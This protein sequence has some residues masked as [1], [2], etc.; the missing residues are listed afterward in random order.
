MLVAYS[1]DLVL[2]MPCPGTSI[3]IVVE[4]VKVLREDPRTSILFLYRTF[5]HVRAK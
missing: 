1:E 2:Y 3:L 5:A 4:D